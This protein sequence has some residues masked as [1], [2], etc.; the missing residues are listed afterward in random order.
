M[1]RNGALMGFM[2]AVCSLGTY[3]TQATNEWWCLLEFDTSAEDRCEPH[4]RLD[5]GEG[6]QQQ[7]S[8]RGDERQRW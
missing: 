1:K 5:H 2:L 8:D 7:G 6:L 3:R 4:G